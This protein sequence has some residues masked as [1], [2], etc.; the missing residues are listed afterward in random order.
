MKGRMTQIMFVIGAAGALKHDVMHGIMFRESNKR[1]LKAR[2]A[3]FG[4]V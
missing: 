1:Q 3:A 4:R 2:Y